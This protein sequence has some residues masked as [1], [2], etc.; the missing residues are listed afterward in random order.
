MGHLGAI[1]GTILG[2]IGPSW[3]YIRTILR[4]LGAISGHLGRLMVLLK[5]LGA[6]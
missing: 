4:Q 6:Y 5:L 3:G 1:V 2:Y